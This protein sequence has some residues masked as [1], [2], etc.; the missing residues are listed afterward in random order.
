MRK[1]QLRCVGTVAMNESGRPSKV[2]CNLWWPKGDNLIHEVLTTM[3]V[4]PYLA[5]CSDTRRGYKVDR[6]LRPDAELVIGERMFY[7]EL[8]TRNMD[9][10]YRKLRRRWRRYEAVN[11]GQGSLGLVLV[12]TSSVEHLQRTVEHSDGVENVGLFTTLDRIWDD[13]Y[14]E[15]W[16]DVTGS[17]CSLGD[18]EMF[19]WDKPKQG[20]ERV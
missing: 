11:T 12:V 17:R 8:D 5:G 15:I 1:R 3:A 10:E 19:S 9:Y 7:V 20:G 2:Y 4:F 18:K 16:E 14:G 13:P 6:Q